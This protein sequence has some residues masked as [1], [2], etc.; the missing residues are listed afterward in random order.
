[1]DLDGDSL[2]DFVVGRWVTDYHRVGQAVIFRGQDDY[3]APA[4][5][6]SGTAGD[7]FGTE[8]AR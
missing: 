3:A 4:V 6:L 7:W 2:P 1:M 5:T 8:I